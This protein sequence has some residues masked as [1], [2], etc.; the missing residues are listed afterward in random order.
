MPVKKCPNGELYYKGAK[1]Y[2]AYMGLMI[3]V[4][5]VKDEEKTPA[6]TEAAKVAY[7]AYQMG[8]IIFYGGIYSNVLEITPPLTISDDEIRH[9]IEVLDKALTNVENGLVSDDALSYAG[10]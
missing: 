4:E 5:L 10:W 6:A 3:G 1:A 7:R 8:L 2:A 9:G